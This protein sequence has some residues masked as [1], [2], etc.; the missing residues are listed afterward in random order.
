MP[1]YLYTYTH[2]YSDVA[3]VCMRLLSTKTDFRKTRPAVYV[4]GN[5]IRIYCTPI[6]LFKQTEC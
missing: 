2:R 3:Y 6:S 5:E 4:G 1:V